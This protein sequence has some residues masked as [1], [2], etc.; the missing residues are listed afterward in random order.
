MYRYRLTVMVIIFITVNAF[1]AFAEQKELRGVYMELTDNQAYGVYPIVSDGDWRR[2]FHDL[3]YLGVNTIFPNVVSPAGAVYPSVVVKQRPSKLL[4]GQS[5]LLKVILVAAHE[6][7]LQV[8]PWTIEWYNAPKHTDPDR[9]MRNAAGKSTNTLCPSIKE[10]R[11]L[12]KN[13]I[14]ELITNYDI[15][16]L[17]YDYMRFPDGGFCYCRHCREG[18]EKKHADHVAEWPK[19]VV[20]GGKLEVAY[21][22]YLYETLNSFVRDMYPLIKKVKPKLPISA[23]VWAREVGSQV[24]GVRQ[25]WGEWV[26]EGVLDFLAPMNY[27]NKWILDHYGDFARNEVKEVA[28]KMPVVF[29]LGAYMDTPERIVKAVKLSRDLK[30]AGFIL[31]TLNARTYKEHLPVL[32]RTVWSQP[33]TV[34]F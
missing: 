19:D 20:K 11:E 25:D 22:S 7:G 33:S 27:G 29:G 31:Y 30:G 26:R 28:A 13:M 34:P 16:G 32:H 15:D 8:H 6:E 18:F 23:A 1:S 9:L 4:Q 12:M 14:M 10:N 2:L 5:D 17:H 24:P 21:Q 3:K